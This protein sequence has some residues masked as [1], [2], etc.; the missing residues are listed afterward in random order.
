MDNQRINLRT[1]ISWFLTNVLGRCSWEVVNSLSNSCKW[2]SLD[3]LKD[4]SL[5]IIYKILWEWCFWF[6]CAFSYGLPSQIT[7]VNRR[8]LQKIEDDDI[9]ANISEK[10]CIYTHGSNLIEVG[11]PSWNLAHSACVA[12][13]TSRLFFIFP[14]K[15]STFP[16]PGTSHRCAV[17]R[18]TRWNKSFLITSIF[19]VR[20]DALHP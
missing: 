9:L 17:V 19:S 6:P 2:L 13:Q 4:T 14:S 7:Y 1:F 16:H 5:I 20:Q 11:I 10:D 15:T 8:W 18:M 3:L 12:R